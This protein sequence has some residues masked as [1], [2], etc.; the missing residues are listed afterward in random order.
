MRVVLE[1]IRFCTIIKFHM[2]SV[3]NQLIITL[4]MYSLK[5]KSVQIV[6][7]PCQMQGIHGYIYP[8]HLTLFSDM[9]ASTSSERCGFRSWG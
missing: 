3:L 5:N 9:S 1:N 8:I 2:F 6:D 7:S 4:N